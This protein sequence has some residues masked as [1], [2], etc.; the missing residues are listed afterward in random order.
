MTT[1]NNKPPHQGPSQAELVMIQG[2]T[3]E[4]MAMMTGLSEEDAMHFA[5][6]SVKEQKQVTATVAQYVAMIATGK[7]VWLQ[8]Q[9]FKPD[10]SPIETSKEP[11]VVATFQGPGQP[12][13]KHTASQ[14]IGAAVGR[15]LTTS[16][17]GRAL[18][19]ANGMRL[20]FKV[21]ES[22]VSLVRE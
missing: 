10:P 2:L 16:Q 1:H 11:E 13:P 9:V 22:P 5:I 12:G 21:S 4:L 15:A 3:R 19:Y 6:E 8:V 17:L 7:K 14:I 18:L 20:R